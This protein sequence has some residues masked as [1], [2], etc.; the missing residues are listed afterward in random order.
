MSHNRLQQ[1]ADNLPESGHDAVDA[2][3]GGLQ[4]KMK[5]L[6]S[7][8]QADLDSKLDDY[9]GGFTIRDEANALIALAVRNGPIEALHAGKHSALLD[10]DSLSR[11]TDAE[12]KVL[13]L[14]ATRMLAKLLGLRETHPELY[15]QYLREYG[16]AYCR[17]W[18][19]E[20]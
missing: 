5:I 6:S 12:M 1:F 15:H 4:A 3:A 11:I 19:R 17:F 18:E 14:N 20:G 7:Q 2:F 16:R 13:M 9:P 10:D 8:E